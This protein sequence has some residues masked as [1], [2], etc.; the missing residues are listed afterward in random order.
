MLMKRFSASGKPLPEVLLV[1]CGR[2]EWIHAN[3]PVALHRC[4]GFKFCF[5]YNQQ[6]LL[7][8]KVFL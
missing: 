5:G 7:R 6:Q 4:P 1:P 2:G 3:A 8:A